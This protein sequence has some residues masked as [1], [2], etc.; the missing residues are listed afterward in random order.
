MKL[1]DMKLPKNKPANEVAPPSPDQ[2]Y[3]YGLRID[4]GN[5]VLEKLGMKSLPTVGAKC[6]I[7]AVGK[8]VRVDHSAESKTKSRSI[9][10]QITKIGIESED[11]IDAQFD[12][13][14]QSKDDKD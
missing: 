4:L 12:K 14:Y 9:A 3:P 8:V 6:E 5:E 13:G 11:D 7:K 2:E 1:V 10:I